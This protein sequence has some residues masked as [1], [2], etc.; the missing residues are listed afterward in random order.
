MNHKKTPQQHH[1]LESFSFDDNFS[2]KNKLRILQKILKWFVHPNGD[3]SWLPKRQVWF[4]F[5]FRRTTTLIDRP[6]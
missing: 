4:V 6:N 3:V 1:K 5:H 2:V